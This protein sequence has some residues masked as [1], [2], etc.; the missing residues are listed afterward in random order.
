[1]SVKKKMKPAKFRRH[2]RH[3]WNQLFQALHA[4][5]VRIARKFKTVNATFE[6]ERSWIDGVH[7]EAVSYDKQLSRNATRRKKG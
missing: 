2:V 4:Q 3:G 5:N 6:V 7:R 1:M